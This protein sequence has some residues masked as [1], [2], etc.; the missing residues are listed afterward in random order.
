[1]TVN[2]QPPIHNQLEYFIEQAACAPAIVTAVVHPVSHNGLV[3][4]IEAANKGLI[5]PILIGPSA[6]IQAAADEEELDISTYE[7]IDVEHSHAAAEKACELAR[8]ACVQ[9]LMKGDLGSSELI[10]AII[11]K[12]TGLRTERRLSHVFVFDV[13]NYHKP[14]IIT[15]GAINVTPSLNDKRDI[16]QNAI[17]F[18]H[19]LGVLSPKVAI[20]AAVEKVKPNMPSTI[21]AACLCKMADRGQI[22]GGILDGP[23]A[24]DNAISQQA[25]LDKHIC[26]DVSGDADI[27]LAPDLEAANMIAKQLIYLAN[28]KS[29]GLALG[30]RVPIILTSRAET[31][32]GRLAS[33]ALASYMARHTLSS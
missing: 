28:A 26:S 17:D 10:S 1:M 9:T 20:L 12:Q 11:N 6:K 19:S 27:L 8:Q 22:T 29:A 15:D 5:T 13:P 18:S 16:I 4:A 3:G 33:C 24:F 30:A 14:L 2:I 21:D 23:L 31:P 7:I 25:A 32:L